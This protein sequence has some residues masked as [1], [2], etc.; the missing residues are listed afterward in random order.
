MH[1]ISALYAVLM[2][3][4]TFTCVNDFNSY[5]PILAVENSAI[6]GVVW[7]SFLQLP[8][9]FSLWAMSSQIFARAFRFAAPAAE[10][11]SRAVIIAPLIIIVCLFVLSAKIARSGSLFPKISFTGNTLDGR[12]CWLAFLHF[13]TRV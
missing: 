8:V 3:R 5:L 12:D 6:V 10:L 7:I 9:S 1:L 11:A 2:A 13:S 4:F